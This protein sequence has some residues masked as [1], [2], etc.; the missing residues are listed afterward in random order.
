[1]ARIE[2]ID[3]VNTPGTP[4]TEFTTR[5]GMTNIA[6]EVTKSSGVISGIVKKDPADTSTPARGGLSGWN[7]AGMFPSIWNGIPRHSITAKGMY[8][9]DVYL[10]AKYKYERSGGG[11]SSQSEGP[12]VA[13]SHGSDTVTVYNKYDETWEILEEQSDSTG[14]R[15]RQVR[16]SLITVKWNMDKN[17]VTKG[18]YP[19][20]GIQAGL[21]LNGSVNGNRLKIYDLEFGLGELRYIGPEVRYQNNEWTYLH[22]AVRRTYYPVE[23]KTAFHW[24]QPDVEAGNV[25]YKHIYPDRVWS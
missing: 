12:R 7:Y 21:S 19:P 20:P 14:H 13:I 10:V 9:G 8:N 16:A 11:G 18:V 3:L 23:N 17:L 1:M 15:G 25:V 2:K 22:V 24:Q 4:G 5:M 6:T